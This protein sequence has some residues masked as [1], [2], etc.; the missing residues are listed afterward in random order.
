MLGKQNK[1][2]N[3]TERWGLQEKNRNKE[4]L[5]EDAH[6]SPPPGL[7]EASPWAHLA[8]Q[9]DGWVAVGEVLPQQQR[10][11]ILFPCQA[12]TVII[13]VK[14]FPPTGETWEGMTEQ[15]PGSR[16]RDQGEKRRITTMWPSKRTEVVA[17][18]TRALS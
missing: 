2:D 7:R 10:V 6:R 12:V 1:R 11:F 13:K 18:E 4:Q 16:G 5:E 14:S 17:K 3:L 9:V 15:E 8:R